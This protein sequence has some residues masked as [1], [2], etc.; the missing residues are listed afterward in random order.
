MVAD[1]AREPLTPH[2]VK[3]SAVPSHRVIAKPDDRNLLSPG[4]SRPAWSIISVPLA[5]TAIF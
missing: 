4:F 5:V 1:G 3:P 2:T